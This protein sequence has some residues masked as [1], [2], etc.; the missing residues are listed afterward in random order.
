[1]SSAEATAYSTRTLLLGL[2]EMT[3]WLRVNDLPVPQVMKLGGASPRALA[4]CGVGDIRVARMMGAHLD[5][6][7]DY[8]RAIQDFG[9]IRL[10]M[11]CRRWDCTQRPP[12][13]RAEALD[14]SGVVDRG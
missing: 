2:G 6:G 7:D 12:A 5:V 8:I 3:D 11:E 4:F 10:T 9:P 13:D 14:L 1:M